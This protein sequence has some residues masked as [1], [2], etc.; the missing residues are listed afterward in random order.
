MIRYSLSLISTTKLNTLEHI[1]K[2]EDNICDEKNL[3]VVNHR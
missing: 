2:R 3:L 1:P